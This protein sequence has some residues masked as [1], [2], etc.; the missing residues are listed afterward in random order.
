LLF[1]TDAD[2]EPLPDW[3][4]RMLTPRVQPDVVG[5]KGVYH[6]RQGSLVALFAQAEHDEIYD[7]LARTD[8]IDFVDTH[9]AA[10]R[11]D[12]FLAHGGFDPEFLLDE[13][14]EFSYRLAS[15]GHRLVFAPAAAVYHQHPSTIWGYAWRKAQIGRWKVWVHARHP[16]KAVRYSYTP[17]TQKAQVAL[18]PL[19][20]VA[21]MA[22]T[23]TLVPTSLAAI[24]AVLG[25]VTAIPLTI[26]AASQGWQVAMI[27]PGLVLLRALALGV[28]LMWGGLHLLGSKLATMDES[29]R[30]QE[31]KQ[32]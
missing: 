8:R 11:R 2:C 15:A 32:L 9:A 14:Q 7:P 23:V 17:W 4:E 21:G 10:Y 18:L 12:L 31:E 20:C 27:A 22:A 5:V 30:N 25:L 16:G 26:R 6:T 29:N 13:D 19:A 3:I 24:F 28:G 1:F